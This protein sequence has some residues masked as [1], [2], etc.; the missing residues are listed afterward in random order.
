MAES[1][2]ANGVA[3]NY[4]GAEEAEY[5]AKCTSTPGCSYMQFQPEF[6]LTVQ[7]SNGEVL[8]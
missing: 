2:A 6:D 4:V 7:L 5:T 3:K 1:V 8:E